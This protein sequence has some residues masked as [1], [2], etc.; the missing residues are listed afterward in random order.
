MPIVD[1]QLGKDVVIPHPELVNLYGCTIGDHSLIGPFVEIQDD[2]TIGTGSSI[3]SHTFVCSKV[4]IGNNVFVAHGVMFTNDRF[5]VRYD[6]S[7]LEETIVEDGVVIG[8]NAVIVSPCR[9]GKDAM[10]AAGAVV[11]KDVP[12]G[13]VVA[14]NPGKVVGTR[15][16]RSDDRAAMRRSSTN[17]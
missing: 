5:P 6:R 7:L 17:E 11:T 9:I 8:S 12:A 4:R 2:V 14:G 1:V 10:V 15:T 16:W 3:Q 13:V